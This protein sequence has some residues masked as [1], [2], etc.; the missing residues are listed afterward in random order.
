M[1]MS[2][3]LLKM[4]AYQVALEVVLTQLGALFAIVQRV[5]NLMPLEDH[6]KVHVVI[7]FYCDRVNSH[8]LIF[9]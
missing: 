2:A 9:K 5:T 6:V 8:V 1:S 3:L 4:D 7:R